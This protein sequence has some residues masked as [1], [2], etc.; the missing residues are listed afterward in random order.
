MSF[1][2]NRSAQEQ[3]VEF[4]PLSRGSGPHTHPLP[5]PSPRLQFTALGDEDAGQYLPQG[6]FRLRVSIEN[7]NLWVSP[8]VWG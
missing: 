3:E 6:I 1:F 2:C 5:A 7:Q 4:E 8:L